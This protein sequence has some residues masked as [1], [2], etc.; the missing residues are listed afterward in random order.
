MSIERESSQIASTPTEP[1]LELPEDKENK[2]RLQEEANTKAFALYKSILQGA[3][4]WDRYTD[5]SEARA[6]LQPTI[7]RLKQSGNLL[8]YL[9]IKSLNKFSV[10]IDVASAAMSED[11]ATLERARKEILTGEQNQE[12]DSRFST[13]GEALS[14][15]LAYMADKIGV[16]VE[17]LVS[18]ND[19]LSQKDRNSLNFRSKSLVEALPDNKTKL[20]AQFQAKLNAIKTYLR[21]RETNLKKTESIRGREGDE[22]Y[23]AGMQADV[24]TELQLL[25]SEGRWAEYLALKG[26]IEPGIGKA[27]TDE[28]YWEKD[29]VLVALEEDMAN[30]DAI[31]SVLTAEQVQSLE[32]ML[33]WSK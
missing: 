9:A 22:K 25:K 3:D 24:G 15:R 21:I 28:G 1:T 8:G 27:P 4:M 12:V 33:S 32:R 20:D 14:L 31:R 7:D 26:T 5:S 6:I 29:L 10:H 16:S 13:L 18:K 17:E 19:S 23:H 30:L 2:T 11:Q